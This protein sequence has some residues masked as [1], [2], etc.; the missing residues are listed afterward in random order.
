M[1]VHRVDAKSDRFA[2]ADRPFV[3]AAFG[4]SQWLQLAYSVEKLGFC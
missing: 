3:S 2:L 4:S 1:S